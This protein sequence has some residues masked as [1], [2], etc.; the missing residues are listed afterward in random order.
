MSVPYCFMG[1]ECPTKEN[2]SPI[3]TVII[4][5]WVAVSI[6]LMSFDIS[7]MLSVLPH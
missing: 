2:I 6:Y 3:Y 5:I 7:F 1:L 4:L